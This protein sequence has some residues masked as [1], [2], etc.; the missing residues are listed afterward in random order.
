MGFT[1]G[2]ASD[3]QQVKHDQEEKAKYHAELDAACAAYSARKEE[4]HSL[5]RERE[6]AIETPWLTARRRREWQRAAVVFRNIG[7][8]LTCF[9]GGRVARLEELPPQVPWPP[10]H[11]TRMREH[12]AEEQKALKEAHL[13]VVHELGVKFGL[14]N[15]AELQLEGQGQ[16]EQHVCV[17]RRLLEEVLGGASIPLG[18]GAEGSEVP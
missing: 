11:L 14:E 15:P 9:Y 10:P 7:I 2:S 18:D 16:Q 3:E 6:A 4:M 8:V 13:A 17:E 1:S 5:Q 12:H